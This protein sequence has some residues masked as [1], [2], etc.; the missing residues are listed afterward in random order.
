MLNLE[1]EKFCCVQTL[2]YG[3]KYVL[4]TKIIVVQF[5]SGPAYRKL[6]VNY[7]KY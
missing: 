2:T 7:I 6:T 1:V 5:S 3:L 4:C